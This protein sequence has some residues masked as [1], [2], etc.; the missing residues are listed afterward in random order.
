MISKHVEVTLAPTRRVMRERRTPVPGVRRVEVTITPE[1]YTFNPNF[2]KVLAD[3]Y[4]DKKHF[5][6]KDILRLFGARNYDDLGGQGRGKVLSVRVVAQKLIGDSIVD[7]MLRSPI[8]RTAFEQAVQLD[9]EYSAGTVNIN[10]VFNFVDTLDDIT[11]NLKGH[12]LGHACF[13]AEQGS[14][15][16]DF[17]LDEEQVN[18][19]KLLIEEWSALLFTFA[20]EKRPFAAIMLNPGHARVRAFKY[21]IEAL[22]FPKGSLNYE[23]DM[24]RAQ[25][26]D[27]AAKS[28]PL[29]F[30][31]FTA[32]Y[33]ALC[34]ATFR[35]VQ[36][37]SLG[38]TG[39]DRLSGYHGAL[40]RYDHIA[41]DLIKKPDPRFVER[42]KFLYEHRSNPK[43]AYKVWR[44]AVSP[45]IDAASKEGLVRIR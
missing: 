2:L 36:V 27:E 28:T 25:I 34:Y 4:Y 32:L 8:F 1:T 44:E 9:K 42:L 13:A 14:S 11:G 21:R 31:K 30:E 26:F 18:N 35:G 10:E 37:E 16:P 23:R 12:D 43:A 6:N 5:P 17:L 3:V 40:S 45:L 15:R 38:P 22:A 29:S 41:R 20:D 33:N 19:R 39:G 7:E 24:T